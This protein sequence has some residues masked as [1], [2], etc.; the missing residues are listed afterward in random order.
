MRLAFGNVI[1]ELTVFRTVELDNIDTFG[2]V[3]FTDASLAFIMF[4]V[5]SNVEVSNIAFSVAYFS[6]NTSDTNV[7]FCSIDVRFAYFSVNEF[8]ANVASCNIDVKFAL[9]I[10]LD[11]DDRDKLGSIVFN[12]ASTYTKELDARETFDKVTFNVPYLSNKVEDE[13]SAVANV[14]DRL[15]DI[16]INELLNSVVFGKVVFKLA[17]TKL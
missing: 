11:K 5:E 2:R 13:S 9:K 10:T 12:D 1:L 6:V 17:S 8:D 3:V 4:A 16:S 14:E 15:E 7:V